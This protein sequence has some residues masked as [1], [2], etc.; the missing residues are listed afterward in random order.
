MEVL[1]KYILSVTS[2]AIVYSLL[3]SLLVKNSSSAILLRTI[4]GL[5]LT[6]TVLAPIAELDFDAIS[7]TPWNYS[8]QGNS[9]AE[10]GRQLSEDRLNEI[11]KT[12]CEAY[13]L[14]KAMSYQTPMH[15]EITLSKD[16]TPVPVA[17][18]LKGS[19]T[20]YAK[21]A[22]QNWLQHDMGIPK[23]NQIWVD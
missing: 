11:I 14:D 5:F 19:I 6:F 15:V 13:I 12:Q 18:Y 23:E 21:N 2:A 20:P 7:D 9:F 3:Q 16:E 8:V 10:H 22:I 4:G 1:G 17:V